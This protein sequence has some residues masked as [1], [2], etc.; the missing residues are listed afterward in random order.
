MTFT[1]RELAHFLGLEH[2]V[3]ARALKRLVDE[4]YANK[5]GSRKTVLTWKDT[6]VVEEVKPKPIAKVAT[7]NR[8]IKPTPE[9]IYEYANSIGFYLDGGKFFDYYQGNGWKINKNPMKDWKATV[10]NWKRNDI[11]RSSIGTEK[12]AFS[13][14]SQERDRKLLEEVK[15]MMGNFRF[16]RYRNLGWESALKEIE[17][18]RERFEDKTVYDESIPM[19]VKIIMDAK[20]FES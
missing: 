16:R 11:M 13:F 10:R 20:Q 17:N 2:G 8:F 1:G 6:V 15:D 3:V 18:H 19:T 4:G 14:D 5:E 7:S 12:K 9:E